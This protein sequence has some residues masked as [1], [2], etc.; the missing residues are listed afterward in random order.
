MEQNKLL[1]KI[2]IY[3]KLYFIHIKVQKFS[4]KV[5]NKNMFNVSGINL[6]VDPLK[7][8]WIQTCMK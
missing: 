4:H 8:L 3:V 6:F 1:K 2:Y 7:S 5:L